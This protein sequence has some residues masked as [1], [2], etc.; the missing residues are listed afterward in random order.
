M[1]LLSVYLINLMS[2]TFLGSKCTMF[3]LF[4]RYNCFLHTHVLGGNL[5]IKIIYLKH[6]QDEFSKTAKLISRAN[7]VM[8]IQYHNTYIC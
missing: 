4:A 3:L 2:V 7:K 1:Q 6:T 8:N 5:I